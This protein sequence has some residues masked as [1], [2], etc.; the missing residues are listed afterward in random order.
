M[1]SHRPRRGG[2]HVRLRR[3]GAPADHARRGAVGV[4]EAALGPVDLL[5]DGRG[6]RGHGRLRR[7]DLLRPGGHVGPAVAV[8]AA[9]PTRSTA[10]P[11]R[12]AG[13]L[14]AQLAMVVLG[15]LAI[16]SEYSTGGIRSTLV[17]VP[18]RSRIVVAKAR[19]GRADSPSSSAPSRRSSPSS[20]A[21]RC[22]P[23]R[24]STTRIGDANVLRA[25]VGTGPLPRRLRAVRPGHRALHPQLRRRHHRRRR[26]A[27]RAA[28]ADPRSSRAVRATRS[29][30]TSPP[31]PA[32]PSPTPRHRPPD[33]LGPWVGYL[34]FTVWWVVLVALGTWLLK[35]RDV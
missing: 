23:P 9:G 26:L 13:L 2:R 11:A 24:T 35:R 34:V 20:P 19:R 3:A 33:R 21:R 7:P 22:S 12:S 18:R 5:D 1:T 14:F 29:R 15:V 30:S 31:T 4:A 8:R 17:A 28:A 16:T 10:P 25:V 6:V 32:R 27:V